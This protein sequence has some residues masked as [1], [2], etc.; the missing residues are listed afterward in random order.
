MLASGDQTGISLCGRRGRSTHIV[1]SPR[2]IKS[3]AVPFAGRT[4]IP[5]L[6]D[7]AN[8]FRVYRRLHRSRFG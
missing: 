7:R 2:W 6:A 5:L 3:F 8:S 1:Q 4:F